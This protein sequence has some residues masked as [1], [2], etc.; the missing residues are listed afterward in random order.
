MRAGGLARGDASQEPAGDQFRAAVVVGHVERVEA[1]AGVFEHG[2]RSRL[3]VEELAAALHVGDLPEAADNARDVESRRKRDAI[4]RVGHRRPLKLR[5]RGAA[6]ASAIF[7]FS[8]LTSSVL[9]SP[10]VVTL[11][12][13]IF[14]KRNGPVMS[15][16]WSNETGPMTPS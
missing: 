15:P 16:Y 12:S 10:T 1:R 4:G 7:A 13:V 2:R 5:R 8:A 6:M 3:R 11:P 14:H 9:I